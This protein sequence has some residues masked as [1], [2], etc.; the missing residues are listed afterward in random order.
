MNNIRI[1]A[2]ALVVAIL[3]AIQFS[4][5]GP[6]TEPQPSGA[7]A[8]LAF[9]LVAPDGDADRDPA[10]IEMLS[11]PFTHETIPVYRQV[12]LD[13]ADV[14]KVELV[15]SDQVISMEMTPQGAAKLKQIT[16]NNIGRR[17][18]IVLGGRIIIAPTI[19]SAV[20]KAVAISLGPSP[21]DD[22][23]RKLTT[24]LEG[25]VKHAPATQPTTQR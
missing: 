14:S 6:T 24:E 22:D 8:R 16:S 12:L 9:R 17:L 7:T 1:R 4:R 18:A 19:R 11:D 13:E 15:P 21:N 3:L 10:K 5:G 2:I 23:L 20:S 25:L